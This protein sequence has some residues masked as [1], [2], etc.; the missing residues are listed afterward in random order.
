MDAAECSFAGFQYKRRRLIIVEPDFH[1]VL[2]EAVQ[3]FVALR[4]FMKAVQ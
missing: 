4:Y 1:T 2:L 3:V